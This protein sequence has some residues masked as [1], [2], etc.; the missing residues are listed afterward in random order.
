MN[1]LV[2]C[3][4][5]KD[6]LSSGEISTVIRS[7]NLEK[8][9]KTQINTISIADGEGGSLGVLISSDKYNVLKHET[10]ISVQEFSEVMYLDSQDG[11]HTNI[12]LSQTGGFSL[13]TPDVLVMIENEDDYT[14]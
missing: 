4:T 9:P 1:I 2:C 12:E 13:Y 11:K 5:F 3:D 8:F 6:S 7:K 14:V 10:H